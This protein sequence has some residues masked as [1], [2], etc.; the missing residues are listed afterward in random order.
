MVT[1]S[2]FSISFWWA[3]RG[4]WRFSFPTRQWYQRTPSGT[5]SFHEKLKLES[6]VAFGHTGLYKIAD[7]GEGKVGQALSL[8]NAADF[9]AVLTHTEL[10]MPSSRAGVAKKIDIIAESFKGV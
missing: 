9:S 2:P 8:D 3:R 5:L 1:K 10:F 4:A 6:H 7:V